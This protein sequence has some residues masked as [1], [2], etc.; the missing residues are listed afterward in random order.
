MK[1]SE[2]SDCTYLLHTQHH[3]LSRSEPLRNLGHE[4]QQ[5]SPLQSSGIRHV[6]F[7][8]CNLVEAVEWIQFNRLNYVTRM[9]TT[10]FMCINY[11]FLK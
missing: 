1:N 3:V 4:S 11:I 9:Q 2:I 8:M 7:A 6:T 5:I 10:F